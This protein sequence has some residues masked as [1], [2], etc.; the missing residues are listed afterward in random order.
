MKNAAVIKRTLDECGIVSYGG[1][2]A[3]YLWAHFPSRKSWDVFEVI[4]ERCF[5][6]TTPGS[7]FGP[8]GEG[9]LRFRAFGNG[10]EVQEACK[11]LKTHFR[12]KE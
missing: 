6:V 2:D 7:G 3:P 8:A 1:V 9:F 4:L 10:E 5:V 11:R 12:K